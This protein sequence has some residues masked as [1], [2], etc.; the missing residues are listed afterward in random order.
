MNNK[1]SKF[2]IDKQPFNKIID[3]Q[4]ENNTR[5]NIALKSGIH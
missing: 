2:I 1:I 5:M 4:Y 3:R